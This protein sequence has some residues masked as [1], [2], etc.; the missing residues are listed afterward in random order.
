MTDTQ[1]LTLDPALVSTERGA[2][3]V[4]CGEDG[5]AWSFVLDLDHRVMQLHGIFLDVVDMPS[6]YV[7]QSA[8]TLIATPSGAGRAFKV[9]PVIAVYRY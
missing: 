7:A 6:L 1:T 2:W 9:P 4:V 8:T 5:R 3:L